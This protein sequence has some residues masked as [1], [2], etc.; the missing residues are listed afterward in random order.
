ME[1]YIDKVKVWSPANRKCKEVLCYAS[2]LEHTLLED[3]AAVDATV[4]D[5]QRLV[6]ELNGRYPR[7]KP[8]QVQRRG[9]YVC[10]QPVE[11]R[12]ED[13]YVFSFHIKKVMRVIESPQKQQQP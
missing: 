9:N 5:L 10:C 4:K 13:E 8:L 7:T 1:Y 11:R 12:V 3:D 2:S 6:E